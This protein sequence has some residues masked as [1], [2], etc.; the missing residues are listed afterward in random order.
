MFALAPN[1]PTVYFY[2]D[3]L[4]PDSPISSVAIGVSGANAIPFQ[5]SHTDFVESHMVGFDGDLYLGGAI[6]LEI[7]KKDPTATATITG[8]M[9]VDVRD[10][11]FVT[12]N[13]ADWI[14]KLGANAKKV[15]LSADVGPFSL[16]YDVGGASVLYHRGGTPSLTF[17]GEVDDT[18]FAGN[19]PLF[20]DGSVRASG[21]LSGDASQSYVVLDGNVKFGPSFAQQKFD[22]T[23]TLDSSGGTIDGKAKFAGTS[24][25]V[26]GSIS[27]S[28]AQLSGS[29]SHKFNAYAGSIE[30]TIRASFDT[31][32]DTVDLDADAKLCISDGLGD[33]TCTKGGADVQVNSD[34]KIRICATIPGYGTTCDTLD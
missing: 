1:E 13:T 8:D 25:D 27:N 21:F 2:S 14:Q 20:P 16:A 23:I 4:F 17:A 12:G 34:G 33:K 9:T 19:L 5:P 18:N 29:I 11:D 22:L 10:A 28:R 32:H 31:N 24:F 15:E 6:G 30:T 26:Q 7:P 3:Q